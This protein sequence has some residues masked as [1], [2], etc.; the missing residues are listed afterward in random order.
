VVIEGLC[1]SWD[2]VSKTSRDEAV[3]RSAA[4]AN[5]ELPRCAPLQMQ[6]PGVLIKQPI[7]RGTLLVT[8]AALSAGSC[9]STPPP[10]TASTAS[11]E[12]TSPHER[13]PTPPPSPP[14]APDVAREADASSGQERGVKR[15]DLASLIGQSREVIEERSAPTG[16]VR[17]IWIEYGPELWL[18]YNRGVCVRVKATLP[19]DAADCTEAG[20]LLGFAS[21]GTSRLDD[22]S[23][24]H[25]LLE[26]RRDNSLGADIHG[27][28][29]GRELTLHPVTSGRC[30]N[31]V[32]R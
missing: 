26:S 21:P 28:L 11:S 25:C 5:A 4:S 3:E 22:D 15:L 23:R 9:E 12:Q 13:S 30:G 16:P 2:A 8:L 1:S 14:A 27:E 19:Q 17:G 20:R 10:S 24:S 7:L 31:R 6:H 29:T 18:A 32:L